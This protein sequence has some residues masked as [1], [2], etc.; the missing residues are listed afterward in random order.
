MNSPFNFYDYDFTTDFIAISKQKEI[1]GI[2]GDFTIVEGQGVVPLND[3]RLTI[4]AKETNVEIKIIKI[5]TPD[6]ISLEYSTDLGKTWESYTI[7]ETITLSKIGDNVKFRGENQTFSKTY[8][9]YYNFVI[10]GLASAS[11]D[12]TSLLNLEGGDVDLPPFC[13][14]QLFM[15]CDLTSTPNLPSTTLSDGSYYA[16]FANCIYLKQGSKLPATTLGQY[17]YAYLFYNCTSLDKAPALPANVLGSDCYYGM[18][19]SCYMLTKAPK[20]PA[21][22]M[23]LGCYT[24]MFRDCTSLVVS[25]ELPAM[26]LNDYCYENMFYGCT[27]LTTA[28][29]LPATTLAQ[30]C[31]S[32]MFYGCTSLTTAPE[33]PAMTLAQTC[34]GN[35]FHDCKALTT[36]PELPATT[37]AQYCYS[38]MF[39]GCS[40]LVT[41]PSILPST[42]LKDYCYNQMFQRCT[43]LT[44]APELPAESLISKC[45]RDM[46]EGCSSLNYIKAMFTTTPTNEYTEAW[47]SGVSATGTFVKNIEATWDVTGNNGVPSGWEILT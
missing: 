39:E 24:S 4:S 31:Y 12:I 20:L 46:F 43:A 38:R 13:F 19:Q 21:T 8:E 36:A 3:N 35:M 2:C 37:L 29:E 10:N 1:L 7:G 17:T 40:L 44:T 14:A 6:D 26:T 27:A 45:Y 22:E 9:N 25:P 42:E 47:V 32:A 34:Y 33:L 16:L 18:F 41:V 30:Y 28:P 5:G 15:S 23:K 11:G